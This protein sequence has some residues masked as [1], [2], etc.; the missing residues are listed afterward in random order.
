MSLILVTLTSP[1]DSNFERLNISLKE[2]TR[3]GV[4][5]NSNG[6]D[7]CVRKNEGKI[8]WFSADCYELKHD[9]LR[10]LKVLELIKL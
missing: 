4:D 5:P 1:S 3:D 2:N 7:Y 6:L 8:L 10:E 9:K